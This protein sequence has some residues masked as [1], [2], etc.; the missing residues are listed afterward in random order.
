MKMNRWGD[1]STRTTTLWGLTSD[2]QTEFERYGGHP[3]H[4]VAEKTAHSELWIQLVGDLNHS[5]VHELRYSSQPKVTTYEGTLMVSDGEVTVEDGSKT[6]ASRSESVGVGEYFYNTGDESGEKIRT[7]TSEDNY[8]L[9]KNLLHDG[10]HE[11]VDFYERKGSGYGDASYAIDV[12]VG[13]MGPSTP[14][15]ISIDAAEFTSQSTETT[16]VDEIRSLTLKYDADGKLT[17][18]VG[19]LRRYGANGIGD[20]DFSSYSFPGLGGNE[21]TNTERRLA[22]MNSVVIPNGV[23]GG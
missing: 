17:S 9:T 6:T 11:L 4:R 1:G 5:Y 18:K 22:I 10:T 20:F 21:V 13:P 19:Y 12:A 15:L 3:G 23:V 14:K 16:T 2:V 8:S 7:W